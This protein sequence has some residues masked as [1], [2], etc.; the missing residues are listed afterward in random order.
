MPINRRRRSSAGSWTGLAEMSGDAERTRAL[1]DIASIAREHGLSAAEIAAAVGEMST[2]SPMAP[3]STL[4]EGTAAQGRGRG[5][6]VHVL[7][8]LGGTF[9]F[10]G[11]GVFIALQWGD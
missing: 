1:R 11:I 5:T 4:S 3:A 2:L 6:L 7:G 10:A 9:V 8:F